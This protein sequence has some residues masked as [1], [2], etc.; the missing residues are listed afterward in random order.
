MSILNYLEETSQTEEFIPRTQEE[1][2]AD[3]K[4]HLEGKIILEFWNKE[5]SF[6]NGNNTP[7]TG[8]V[9]SYDHRAKLTIRAM[10]LA[11]DEG[12]KYIQKSGMDTLRLAE[13]TD[14]DIENTKN[15]LRRYGAEI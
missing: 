5:Y 15:N 2:E 6:Q 1:K 8:K 14:T 7:I 3:K 4:A 13:V 10:E 9:K 11:R 12:K